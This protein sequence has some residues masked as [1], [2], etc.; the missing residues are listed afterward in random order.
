MRK[1]LSLFCALAIV[2]SASAA[3]V[4]KKDILTKK[5]LQELRE[6][7]AL[8][9]VPAKSIQ[10]KSIEKKASAATA[11]PEFKV[12]GHKAAIKSVKVL[13][14]NVAKAPKA[15]KETITVNFEEP[16]LKPY[17]YSDGSCELGVS[18]EE[19][20][21]TLT[22]FT[23]VAGD[24]TGDYTEE[25]FDL[26]WCSF[27]KLNPGADYTTLAI[28]SGTLS[29]T[30]TDNRIDAN[31][32]LVCDDGNT[33]EISM[34]YEEAPIVPGEYDFVATK[35]THTFYSSDNDVYY[36]F[37]DAAGNSIRFDI[38]VADGL[39]DVELGK[40]YT[41]EDML[42]SYSDVTY[43]KVNADFKEVS[44][45]KTIVEGAEVYSA[46]ATDEYDRVFALNYSFK[47]PEALNFET[48][49]GPVSVTEEAVLFWTQY[50]FIAQDENNAISLKIMPDDTYF[51][52]W[53]AG[54]DITGSVFNIATET[55]SDIYSGEVTIEQQAEGFTITGKV[56]C[57]NNTE[58]TLNLTYVIPDATREAEFTLSGMELNVY[59]EDGIWQIFGFNED[60]TQYATIAVYSDVVEGHYTTNDLYADYCA[61][62]TDLEFDEEGNMIAGNQF[63][64]LKA[65]I[66]VTFNEA[67]STVVITGTFR[68]QNGIDVP[69]FALNLSGKIPAP[70][71]S[72]ITFVITEDAETGLTVTPSNNDPWDFYFA[73]ESVFA[74]YGA[75]GI[76]E[77]IYGNYGNKY[78]ISGEK[79]FAWDDEELLY[80]CSEGGIFYLV[81]WGSGE[82]NVTSAAASHE[83]EVEAS[84]DGCT[85]YDAKEDFVV[86]FAEFEADD[87][88]IADGNNVI[89]VWAENEN[90]EFINLQ[91][92]LPEGATELIAG[93]YPI[94]ATQGEPQTVCA[95]YLS[96]NTLG[97]SYAGSFDAEGYINVP[98]WFL[99]EGKVV[100]NEDLS[101]DVDAVNCPGAAIQ[102]HLGV[103]SEAVENVQSDKVQCTKVLRNGQLIIEKNGVRYSTLGT[104]VK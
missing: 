74:Q 8:K 36:R 16:M 9:K 38:V 51:G 91:I 27:Y 88:N 29:V 25:N 104:V 62:Y 84:G 94:S 5:D 82:R 39:E 92:W 90:S 100:V 98:F 52:T 101:I 6:R 3:P 35:E 96:G 46:T 33:Y 13:N 70:E 21:L 60:E 4:S 28:V 75:D 43:D 85:Q 55:P 65:E 23:T 63:K 83:F 50:T 11:T 53:E 72:D 7:K 61:L 47:A 97:G 31:A 45:T 14:A 59:E 30:K 99:V 89:L 77:A 44:F 102:C 78:A 71:V 22:Y 58:Y 56:L 87:S 73:S 103:S 57:L 49:T 54:K 76:A 10:L 26:E 15:K 12:Q 95:G 18:N 64:L 42:A 69:E 24:P 34:F 32:T 37:S 86:N 48:I 68:G 66:D 67:D 79:T 40:E 41:L 20:D 81:V 2:L 19:Y 17:F 93:E 80:Y 1:F